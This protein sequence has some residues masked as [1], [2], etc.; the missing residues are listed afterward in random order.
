FTPYPYGSKSL[1]EQT[2]AGIELKNPVILTPEVLV[3][4]KR[5]YQ[6]FCLS[7]HGELGD[8]NGHL[9]TSKMFP[10]KPRNLIDDYLKEKPDGEIFHVITRG[11]AAG[12]MG[13]HGGQIPAEKRWMIVHYVRELARK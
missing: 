11:S 5:Q 7:C 8:G 12:L 3:E 2:R 9:F 1:E 4:G 10:A 13:P 6:I